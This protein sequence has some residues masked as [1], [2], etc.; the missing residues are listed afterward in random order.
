MVANAMYDPSLNETF[1]DITNKEN[2]TKWFGQNQKAIPIWILNELKDN[3]KSGAVGGFPGSIAPILNTTISYS[4][5]YDDKLDW[6]DMIDNLIDLFTKEDIKE[7]INLGVLYFEDPDETGHQYG[8]Y[9]ENVKSVLY[10]CDAIIGYLIKRLDQVGLYDDMNI[11]I[12]SDHGMDTAEFNKSID[13]SDYTDTTKFK[14][15]GGL[16]QINIFPNDR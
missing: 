4:I 1:Y 2:S 3:R 12:T 8:P 13:L 16:T 11:I 10:K 7:R 9:S 14:S 15:Y 6:F 5:N